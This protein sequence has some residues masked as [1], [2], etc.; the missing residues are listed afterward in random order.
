MEPIRLLLIDDERHLLNNFRQLLEFENFTVFTAANGVEGL[1]QFHLHKPDLIICDIAMP[2]MDGFTFLQKLRADGHTDIPFIFLSAQIDYDELRQSM[3]CGADDYLL[4]PVKGSQLI[5][6][7]RTRLLRK[8][9][10][11][12][13]LERDILRVENGFKL[14]ADQE[15]FACMFDVVSYL[16]LL[17]AKY[18]QTDEIAVREYI[19]HI[20]KATQKLMNLL[21]KVKYWQE[22]YDVLLGNSFEFNGTPVKNILFH[23]SLS[24]ALQYDRATDLICGSE[25]EVEVNIN[26]ELLTILLNELLDNAFKFSNKGNPVVVGFTREKDKCIIMVADCGNTTTA[27][28]LAFTKPF[29]KRRSTPGGDAGPGLG[30]AIIALIVKSIGGE[31]SFLNNSPCGV[32]VTVKIPVAVKLPVSDDDLINRLYIAQHEAAVA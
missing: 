28:T 22:N 30:L 5:G 17:K 19:D 2:E 32:L 4:K 14:V 13:H 21:N 15:M 25:E 24:V 16:N 18:N 1:H 20:E 12:R 26:E 6:S 3:E 8:Q 27:Q 29:E 7:I 9:E 10:I 23:S 11:N 31:L